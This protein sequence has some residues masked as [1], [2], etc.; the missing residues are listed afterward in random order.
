M[1]PQTKHA[2]ANFIAHLYKDDPKSANYLDKKRC[3][4]R[5]YIK[6]GETSKPLYIKY[7]E[8]QATQQEPTPTP[9]PKPPP[10]PPAA[11]PAPL[12]PTPPA[13]TQPTP[14]VE[15]MKKQIRAMNSKL[16]DADEQIGDLQDKLAHANEKLDE[17]LH[18]YKEVCEERN[19]LQLKLE[20]Q[21]MTKETLA[22]FERYKEV[23]RN[24]RCQASKYACLSSPK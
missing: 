11:P 12:E 23:Y 3:E 21:G 24:C 19:R 7:Q 9:T 16:N 18:D 2:T 22:Q 1:N 13:P 8:W 17:I 10:P 15:R 14:D 5:S 20:G 6:K 4:L